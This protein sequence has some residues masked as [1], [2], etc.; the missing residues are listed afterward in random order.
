MD[1]FEDENARGA[2]ADADVKSVM[3]HL[4]RIKWMKSVLEI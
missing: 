3:L 1:A 2:D 4:G